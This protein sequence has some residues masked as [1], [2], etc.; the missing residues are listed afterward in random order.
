MKRRLIL[1]RH[2]E[3]AWPTMASSDHER[4]LNEEGLREAPRVAARLL[5]LGWS[6][7][8]VL[9]SDA[10]RTRETW[11][12]MASSMSGAAEPIFTHALYHAGLE[13]LWTEA[14]AI[15]ESLETLLVLGHNPGWEIALYTLCGV[16]RTMNTAN[17]A[18]LEGWGDDWPSAL[19]GRWELHALICPRALSTP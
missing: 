10:R 3:S 18:L 16:H 2:A 17:A 6:P 7:S 5:E 13:E 15:D 12:A 11:E 14:H 8:G 19:S 9:S 4:P 1:M